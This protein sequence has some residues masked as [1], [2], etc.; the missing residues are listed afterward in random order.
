MNGIPEAVGSLL[1]RNIARA[2]VLLLVGC[3]G[4]G[5]ECVPADFVGPLAPGQ[6]YCKG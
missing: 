1:R 3:G 2:C 5:D 4:G 6:T